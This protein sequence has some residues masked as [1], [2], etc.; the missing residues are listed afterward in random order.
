M[1]IKIKTAAAMQLFGGKIARGCEVGTIIYLTGQLGVGKTTLVRGFLRELGYQ[2]RVRSPT[3]TLVE[4][5][6]IN[7]QVIYHFDL[8]RLTLGQELVDLGIRD[9]FTEQSIGL[10][11]WPEHGKGFLPPADLLIIFSEIN[12][13]RAVRKIQLDAKTTK[14]KNI[15][16]YFI[17]NGA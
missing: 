17:S 10:I 3:F 13:G 9:Y 12:S 2:G 14:G 15:M 8:Y 7:A 1:L 4:P 11:E 16:G 6:Q 5:Y